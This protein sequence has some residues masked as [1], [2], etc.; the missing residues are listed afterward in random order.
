MRGLLKDI[1]QTHRSQVSCKPYRTS[2]RINSLD[3]S[4]HRKTHDR[5]YSCRLCTKRFALMHDLHRHGASHQDGATPDTEFHCKWTGC[6]QGYL[7]KD[8]LLKHMKEVHVNREKTRLDRQELE[9][10][11]SEVLKLYKESTRH[12]KFI[13]MQSTMRI[14]LLEGAATGDMFIVGQMLTRGID[15]NTA[16]NS[17]STSLLLAASRGHEGCVKIL[18][19]QG[20]NKELV[21][22][23]GSTPLALAA[24]GGHEGCVKILLD[25]GANKESVDISGRTPLALA[26]SKGHEGCV[27]ILLDQGAN[28]E[29]VDISGRTLLALA[30][31][32]GH[33]GCVKILLD[34]GA[35][36]NSVDA[37]GRTPLSQAAE[38]GYL[39]VVQQLLRRGASANLGCNEGRT[40]LWYARDG[41]LRQ[42]RGELPPWGLSVLGWD[43]PIWGQEHKVITVLLQQAAQKEL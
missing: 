31:S 12:D 35:N 11:E 36:K 7:R 20:A 29:L 40:P 19:D 14:A 10:R 28:K 26:V 22:I 21:D 18:L 16:G 27:K 5:P 15:I 38:L 25:Q 9:R 42:E 1:S 2:S 3:I 33:E 39:A 13:F 37:C 32:K 41:A 6:G 8:N 23:L 43:S 30:A 17:R 34:K 4:R 24:S